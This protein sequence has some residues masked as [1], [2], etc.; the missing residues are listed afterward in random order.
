M[1]RW[2]RWPLLGLGLALA[3]SPD[4]PTVPADAPQPSAGDLGSPALT[5]TN[6]GP[7]AYVTDLGSNTVWVIDVTSR[8]VIAT[9]PVG[10]GP[11]SVAI[12]PNGASAYVINHFGGNV[13]E[14]LKNPR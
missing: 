7:R 10:D 8:S 13:N 3:C 12:T 14:M 1:P 11:T 6:E 5:S 2:H 9:V 4:L